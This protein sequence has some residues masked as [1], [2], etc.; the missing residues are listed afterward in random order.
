MRKVLLI[1]SFALTSAFCFAQTENE[2][3]NK[4][5]KGTNQTTT[6]KDTVI[7]GRSFSFIEE[8]VEEDETPASIQ[9]GY[10]L[11]KSSLF[12]ISGSIK[13]NWGIF[14]CVNGFHENLSDELPYEHVYSFVVGP[15]FR[16]IKKYPFYISA[17]IGYGERSNISKEMETS[18][19]KG[20]NYQMGI[21]YDF[22]KDWYLVGITAYYDEYA[23]VGVGV[24]FGLV[25]R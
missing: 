14:Y 16:I 10:S 13:K 20:F 19:I 8:S 17:G 12:N 7:S 25:V 5:I 6:A 23:K 11:S 18:K 9:I 21:E 24:S 22:Y 4:W 3:L 15:T 1:L 2:S